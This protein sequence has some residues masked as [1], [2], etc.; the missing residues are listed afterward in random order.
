L[1][2]HRKR[3]QNRRHD[4]SLADDCGVDR[5]IVATCTILNYLAAELKTGPIDEKHRQP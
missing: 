1:Q 2:K 5:S 4:A 3:E